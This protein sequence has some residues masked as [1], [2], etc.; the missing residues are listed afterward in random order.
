M[1]HIA[2]CIGKTVYGTGLI[3]K[4]SS[5]KGRR[6]GEELPHTSPP[7]MAVHSPAKLAT[8]HGKF[9]V[10]W[11]RESTYAHQKWLAN[12]SPGC[13]PSTNQIRGSSV[14]LSFDRICELDGKRHSHSFEPCKGCYTSALSSD[15]IE[16]HTTRTTG[17]KSSSR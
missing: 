3:M 12:H 2:V 14:G 16:T 13:A 1:S 8:L 17:N 11:P 15:S 5:P 4:G 9:L 6:G 10:G 7:P